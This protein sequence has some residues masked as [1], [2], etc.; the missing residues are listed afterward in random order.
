MRLSFT[1]I[2]LATVLFPQTI[3][4]ASVSSAAEECGALGVMEVPDVLPDGVTVAD[5]RKCAG[6]PL[7]LDGGASRVTNGTSHATRDLETRKE[8]A[9]ETGA[10]YGCTRGFCWKVC[11][12]KGEWC[13]T[14]GGGGLGAWN[15]CQTYRDCGD[16]FTWTCGIG[17]PSCGCS[18]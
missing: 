5:V 2:A 14:A 9:C 4:A 10:P 8:D 15:T 16:S 17:C 7:E 1:F 11:G 6:H 3:T 12:P 13:W 18:C